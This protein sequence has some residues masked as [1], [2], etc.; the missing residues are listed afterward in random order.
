MKSRYLPVPWEQRLKIHDG[1][2]DRA[3]RKTE[4]ITS[5]EHRNAFTVNLFAGGKDLEAW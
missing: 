3:T 5:I 2:S 1:I 4:C